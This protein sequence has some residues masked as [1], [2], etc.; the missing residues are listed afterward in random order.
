MQHINK[1]HCSAL[2]FAVCSI[3]SSNAWSTPPEVNVASGP[4]FGA[5]CNASY[6][7]ASSMSLE[8]DASAS[9]AKTSAGKRF[10]YQAGFNTSKWSGSLKK[11]K[12]NLDDESS[13][14][15]LALTTEWSADDVLTGTGDQAPCPAPDARNIFT[16]KTGSDKSLATVEFK[17][18]KL[19]S[20]QQTWLNT[21]PIDGKNDGLGEKRLNYLRGMRTFELGKPGGIFRARDRLLGDI[22]NSNPVYVGAPAAGEQGAD[23]QTFYEANKARAKTVYIGAN[24]GMLHAFGADDGKELFAYV[25][26]AV[27][28]AMAQ[29]TQPEYV[30]R[31]YVDGGISI[32][33]ARVGSKW[34]S[35]LVS[36]MGGGAQGLFALDVTNPSDFKGGLGVVFEFT[37][38]D[39]PHMGNLAG[40]P[41]IG[42]FKTNVSK[43]VPE[44]KYFVVAAGGFNNYKDDGENRF[45]T[46]APG[47]L[48]LLSLDKAPSE[49]W[50]EGVNYFKFL[51]PAKDA[52]LQ[53]GLGSPAL[54]L[55]SD[56]A[57]R[58]VY[59][60][61]LQGN[62]WR[63]DFTGVSP[64]KSALG[65]E[66]YQPIFT[67]K[68]ARGERQPITVQP[69]IAFA[70]GGGYL[71]LF[72]TG[73]FVEPADSAAGNFKVQ[74]FYGIIDS[75]NDTGIVSGRSELAGRALKKV[76][77]DSADAF[78][79][80]GEDVVNGADGNSKK[81]W[82]FDFPDSDKTG[83][84][85][86]SNPLIAFGKLFFNSL[87]PG[88]D[89][90][91]MGSSRAYMLDTLTGLAANGGISGYIS[92][93]GLMS[94]PFL[95]EV[96]VPQVGDRNAIGKRIVKKKYS[97]FNFGMDGAKGMPIPAP[98]S[99]IEA[100]LPAGR[101]SWREILNWP[102]L[103]D[104]STKKY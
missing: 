9:S 38:N 84:R 25:P 82:Y 37:D 66:P 61:D 102:E 19:T 51:A 15:M 56:G 6:D 31:P 72:G 27:M 74:S 70:P 77:A 78:S 22:V 55:G 36:G 50:R 86:V 88:S 46:A 2:M 53:N 24:D 34:K 76:M 71:I 87:I 11:R 100:D 93:T 5:Y 59:A 60:G 7:M 68:D 42:R 26:N 99:V 45:D 81:G 96:G 97:V 73:K 98:D 80:S 12:M 58:Y 8:S 90:C 28:P 54:A 40:T 65:P 21:S 92:P 64:W 4:L 35:I 95:V 52:G 39:D 29:L 103:R 33:E 16:A 17:W 47:A 23:Y 30:H 41:V 63:F 1:T 89:P 14:R 20:Q 49:K 3:L 62:M 83:E 10:V 44:Y 79:I 94:S 18:D 101:I 75:L 48:F 43:D 104:A 69:K 91:V 57:V 67:A 85:S 32:G 13:I